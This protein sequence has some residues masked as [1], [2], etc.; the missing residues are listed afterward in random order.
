MKHTIILTS[1]SPTNQNPPSLPLSFNPSFNT[2]WLEA[3]ARESPLSPSEVMWLARCQLARRQKPTFLRI[4]CFVCSCFSRPSA[5]FTSSFFTHHH[6]CPNSTT[7][8]ELTHDDL[9]LP[10]NT[11][12]SIPHQAN[13]CSIILMFPYLGFTNYNVNTI[14]HE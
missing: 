6:L 2:P 8:N 7:K 5:L 12:S 3:I 10:T 11:I 4:H 1:T 14:T 9:P 13:N